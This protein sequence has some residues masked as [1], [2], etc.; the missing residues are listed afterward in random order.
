[1]AAKDK[2][3]GHRRNDGPGRSRGPGPRRDP[4]NRGARRAGSRRF[5]ASPPGAPRRRV[6]ESDEP[7][8]SSGERSAGRPGPAREARRGKTPGRPSPGPGGRTRPGRGPSPRRET[9]SP[10]G[11]TRAGA[12]ASSRG[13]PK[14]GR[15][16]VEPDAEDGRVPFRTGTGR[17]EGGSKRG[18]PAPRG[19]PANARRGP[20]SRDQEDRRAA[21]SERRS[22][23]PRADRPPRHAGGARRAAPSERRSEAAGRE[24]GRRAGM[25]PRRREAR[26]P[27]PAAGPIEDP[28]AAERIQKRLAAAGVGSRRAVDQWVAEGRVR[29]N[30]RVAAAGTRVRS[31]DR[32]EEAS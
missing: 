3:D 1:M 8:H 4:P 15:A 27:H 14:R 17:G 2:G 9:G 30:G 5:D 24:L 20:P 11:S 10:D 7:F 28:A 31:G 21:P 29:I 25:G 13:S 22:S 12:P 16:R 32:V 23:R 6:A 18:R 19:R 26:P